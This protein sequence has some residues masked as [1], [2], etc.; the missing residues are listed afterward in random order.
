MSKTECFGFPKSRQI[1]VR[2]AGQVDSCPLSLRK[3]LEKKTFG[4]Q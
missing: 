1:A 3:L 2:A 4:A